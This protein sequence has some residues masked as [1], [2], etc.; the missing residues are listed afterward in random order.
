[1]IMIYKLE[2]IKVPNPATKNNARQ[3]VSI[4]LEQK[5]T[6]VVI[7][8]YSILARERDGGGIK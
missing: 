1:M 5:W 4:A 7:F 6:N 2:A 8:S 3:D